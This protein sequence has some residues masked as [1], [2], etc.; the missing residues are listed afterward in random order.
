MKHPKYILLK[1]KKLKE[2]GC[3]GILVIAVEG[4]K[5]RGGRGKF[6]ERGGG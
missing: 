2:K 3:M 6:V 1:Y 5:K 4:E